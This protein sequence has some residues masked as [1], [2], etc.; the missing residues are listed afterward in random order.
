VIGVQHADCPALSLSLGDNVPRTRMP[1]IETV[2]GGIEGGL[3]ARNFAI[4]RERID[5]VCLVDEAMIRAATAWIVDEHQLIAEPTG[6]VALAAV[7]SGALSSGEG[8]TVVLITGRNVAL[9]T[10]AAILEPSRA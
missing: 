10:L 2:A 9:A 5:G 4:L 3:G 8:E 6:A 7:L 1:A